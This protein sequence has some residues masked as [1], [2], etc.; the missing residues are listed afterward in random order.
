M[1][2]L[3][4]QNSVSLCGL[5]SRPLNEFPSIQWFSSMNGLYLI[6]R[7]VSPCGL[8]SPIFSTSALFPRTSLAVLC[9]VFIFLSFSTSIDRY[10]G[11]ICTAHTND[12]S[13]SRYLIYPMKIGTLFL[14]LTFAP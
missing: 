2:G 3:F 14:V 4:I 11:S 6:Q 13:Y 10:P 5:I 9:V 12:K 7:S 8:I 1:N